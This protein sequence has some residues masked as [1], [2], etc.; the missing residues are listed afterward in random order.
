MQRLVWLA[1]AWKDFVTQSL[2]LV[3]QERE[4]PD[5]RFTSCS[6]FWTF[7][8]RSQGWINKHQILLPLRLTQFV[9]SSV[10]SHPQD[11]CHP[12]QAAESL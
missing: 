9:L 3:L 12:W 2:Q 7:H 5:L 11:N 4:A 6:A 1:G 8:I 10:S